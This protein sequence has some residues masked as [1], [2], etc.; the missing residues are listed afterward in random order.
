M[1]FGSA[2]NAHKKNKNYYVPVN[3]LNAVFEER[4]ALIESVK[5]APCFL[6]QKS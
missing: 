5:S 4:Q 2:A 1:S 3:F 6:C